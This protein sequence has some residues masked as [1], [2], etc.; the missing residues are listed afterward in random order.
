[1]ARM[2]IPKGCYFRRLAAKVSMI[3]VEVKEEEQSQKSQTGPE[4]DF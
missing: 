2:D 4:I 1:M 3:T